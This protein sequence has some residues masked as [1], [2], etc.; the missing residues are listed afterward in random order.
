MTERRRSRSIESFEA[1]LEDEA[2]RL[3]AEAELLPPGADRDALLRKAQQAETGAQ[4]SG[5]LRSRELQPPN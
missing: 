5:W 3:R 1:R 4:M 2:K